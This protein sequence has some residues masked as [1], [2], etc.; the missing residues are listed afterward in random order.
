M[1]EL[2]LGELQNA[3]QCSN[4]NEAL[5]CARYFL[6]DHLISPQPKI[7]IVYRQEIIISRDELAQL[8]N[9]VNR[10]FRNWARALK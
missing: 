5:T 7:L 4:M 6:I 10:R 8:K 1:R 2:Y 9:W 3:A